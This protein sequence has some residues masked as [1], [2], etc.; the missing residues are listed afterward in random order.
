MC[1]DSRIPRLE[2]ER[3]MKKLPS[4][5]EESQAAQVCGGR[6]HKLVESVEMISSFEI[7]VSIKFS[8]GARICYCVRRTSGTH[9]R[10][11]WQ[12]ASTKKRGFRAVFDL[13]SQ[14]HSGTQGVSHWFCMGLSEDSVR[15][16]TVFLGYLYMMVFLVS[17]K[18]VTSSS[19]CD[20]E[21]L[22]LGTGSENKILQ[23]FYFQRECS[24][25]F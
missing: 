17:L 10:R 23:Y 21:S 19:M 16:F 18:G 20:H 4:E 22:Q 3:H 12:A 14:G 13:Q 25:V 1:I 5:K 7:R 8:T 15:D 11:W 9:K 24:V 2:K 6:I